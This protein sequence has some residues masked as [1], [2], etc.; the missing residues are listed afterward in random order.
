MSDDMQNNSDS[1]HQTLGDFPFSQQ[2]I[3]GELIRVFSP[4]VEEEELKWHFDLK[5]RLVKILESNDWQFQL[6]DSLPTKLFNGQEIYIP[7][8][9]WHRVIK[10]SGY[11][12]VSI[13]EF[14]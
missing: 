12:K 14:D 9:V 2:E 5:N 6:E 13:K 4:E 11:L 8:F 7:Q 10:G 1:P 3:G